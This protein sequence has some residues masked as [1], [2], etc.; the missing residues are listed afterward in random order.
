MY[1]VNEGGVGNLVLLIMCDDDGGSG[2]ALCVCSTNVG[3]GKW[4]VAYL[5][6]WGVATYS[7]IWCG[8]MYY[9]GVR[10]HVM[11]CDLYVVWYVGGGGGQQLGVTCSRLVWRLYF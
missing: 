9:M 6:M 5:M 7:V 2:V 4:F 11:Q 1:L 10:G 3:V 8:V